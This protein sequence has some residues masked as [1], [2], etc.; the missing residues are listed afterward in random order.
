MDPLLARDSEEEAAGN[1]QAQSQEARVKRSYFS[2]TEE[3]AITLFSPFIATD[4]PRQNLKRDATQ[5]NIIALL[6]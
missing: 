4:T 2:E 1:G 5:Q 3:V 6:T